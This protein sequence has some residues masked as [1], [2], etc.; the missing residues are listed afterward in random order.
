MIICGFLRSS[1]KDDIPPLLADLSINL[2][3]GRFPSLKSREGN[4]GMNRE[5]TWEKVGMSV[6]HLIHG[7]TL[8]TQLVC[9][10][11][12]RIHEPRPFTIP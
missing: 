9:G 4:A 7:V 8:I 5:W 12:T 2:G 3:K 11:D 10:V 6:R 1:Q